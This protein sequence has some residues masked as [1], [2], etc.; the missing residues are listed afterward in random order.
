M[1]IGVLGAGAFGTALARAMAERGHTVTLWARTPETAREIDAA[2][3]NVRYLP[4]V[5]LPPSLSV[6]SDLAAAVSHP[7]STFVLGAGEHEGQPFIAMELM[8]GHTLK[9]LVDDAEILGRNQQPPAY[10]RLGDIPE[11]PVFGYGFEAMQLPQ[12]PLRGLVASGAVN[13]PLLKGELQ[14]STS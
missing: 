3:E 6:T 12:Q 13:I 7:R 14:W 11:P 8:P 2:R 9:D 1:D 5:K 10:V 4:G